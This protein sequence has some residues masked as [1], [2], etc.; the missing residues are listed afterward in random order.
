MVLIQ[1]ASH[2][3]CMTPSVVTVLEVILRW[4]A[5]G[6]I[7]IILTFKDAVSSVTTRLEVVIFALVT[8]MVPRI[9]VLPGIPLVVVAVLMT[10]MVVFVFM[11][12]VVFAASTITECIS[13]ETMPFKLAWMGIS[14]VVDSV[15]VSSRIIM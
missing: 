11:G 8:I 3:L 12:G 15:I 10:L 1:L 14:I 9:E 2:F 7:T 5:Q 13:L 6:I 4:A